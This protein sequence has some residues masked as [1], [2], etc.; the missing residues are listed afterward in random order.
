MSTLN[1]LKCLEKLGEGTYGV[2]Y[3][4]RELATGQIVAFKRM[5]INGE[6]EGV[7]ATAIREVCL[8]RELKHDNIVSLRDVLFEPP[9]MTL[10]FEYCEYDLKK[11]MDR[12]RNKPV[13]ELMK[14]VKQILRQVLVGL[15]YMHRKSVVHRDLKPENIFLNVGNTPHGMSKTTFSEGVINSRKNTIDT[16]ISSATSQKANNGNEPN[17]SLNNTNFDHDTMHNN[18]RDGTT[19]ENDRANVNEANENDINSDS[20]N[21]VVKLGDY[22]LARVENIPVKKYS[23]D[24][25]SLWYRSPDVMMGTA[26]YG[27]AVDMWSVGCIFAEM[28]T[29]KPLF[30]GRT[31]V[32]QL[33][34]IFHLL[35][36]PTPD[37][38][39]SMMTYPKTTQ[40]LGAAQELVRKQ[41]AVSAQKQQVTQTL[42]RSNVSQKPKE[43][44]QDTTRGNTVNQPSRSNAQGTDEDGNKGISAD[45]DAIQKN[46]YKFPPELCFQPTFSEYV[47][48][49]HFRERAG[50]DGVD[51][52]Q[53]LVC[54]EPS[55]RLTAHEALCHP[56]MRNVTSRPRRPVDAMS[57]L[58]RQ[59]L[60]EHGLL[61]MSEK[62]E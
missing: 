60:E 50:D 33:V 38:W 4:A 11:Y 6:D 42:Q 48:V 10:V 5:I 55:Q 26:L 15:R 22:G 17:H 40:L 19:L 23:H 14:E 28:V 36:T 9:K 21:L 39:P 12:N 2:V 16:V 59:A 46:F 51:L 1:R 41:A 20:S 52:L 56:F 7:P 58:L 61:G 54:Y 34:K 44:Q 27:F 31:D 49:S 13:P 62:N 35:G 29:G 25:V 24:V 32:D 30:S 43:R 57:T 37:N 53:K 8:L 18:T 3:K 47:E 45:M